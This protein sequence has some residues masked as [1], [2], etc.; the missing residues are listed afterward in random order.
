MLKMEKLLPSRLKAMALY[1]TLSRMSDNLR[2]CCK[3]LLDHNRSN[4]LVSLRNWMQSYKYRM[5]R[6]EGMCE[7]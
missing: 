6:V 2:A 1:H 7:G 5:I 4:I 3:L